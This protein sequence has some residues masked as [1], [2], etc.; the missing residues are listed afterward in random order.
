MPVRFSRASPSH[1]PPYRTWRSRFCARNILQLR[2]LLPRSS[3]DR[4]ISSLINVLL[5]H[6]LIHRRLDLGGGGRIGL[7]LVA[8]ILRSAS[9]QQRHRQPVSRPARK[10]VLLLSLLRGL[11]SPRRRPT[12]HHSSS[13][14]HHKGSVL[15]VLVLC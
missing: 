1:T 13:I 15:V 2:S 5:V 9:N 14:H 8:D 10:Q 3:S 11:E 12:S 6:V 7:S 4:L